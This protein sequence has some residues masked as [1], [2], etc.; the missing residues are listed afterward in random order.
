MHIEIDEGYHKA[1]IEADKIREED[2]VGV[3]DH[4]V[5]GFDVTRDLSVIHK[6]IESVV[7]EIKDKINRE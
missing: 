4:E 1:N 6:Q 5:R 7:L 3:T 2:I